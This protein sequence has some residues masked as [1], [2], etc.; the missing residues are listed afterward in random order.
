[1]NFGTCCLNCQ[2]DDNCDN[3]N[4]YGDRVC[5]YNSGSLWSNEISINGI[6]TFNFDGCINGYPFFYFED[7][8]SDKNYYLY[9]ETS[10]DDNKNGWII[11]QGS[12]FETRGLAYCLNDD[13]SLCTYNNWYVGT[14]VIDYQEFE[15]DTSMGYDSNCD[16]IGD[17]VVITDDEN[18]H[19][20]CSDSG[21]SGD[22][23]DSDSGNGCVFWM[24]GMEIEDD[25]YENELCD[26]FY[27]NCVIESLY[28][29]NS[30]VDGFNKMC[31]NEYKLYIYVNVSLNDMSEYTTYSSFINDFSQLIEECVDTSEGGVIASTGN[32]NGN[33]FQSQL[34][35]CQDCQDFLT[36]EESGANRHGQLIAF[37]VLGL[38]FFWCMIF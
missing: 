8:S 12:I 22:N 6:G 14:W 28:T 16:G 27:L 13:L 32:V 17:A 5:V 23:S 30:N 38:L 20:A 3:G 29:T 9:Y 24:I 33:I 15:I 4:T 1:M 34:V 26:D 25:D 18:N 19:P 21:D 2:V 7:S 31:T 37:S 11:S 10:I 35:L 36:Q